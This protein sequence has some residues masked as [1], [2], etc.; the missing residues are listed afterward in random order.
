MLENLPG[1]QRNLFTATMRSRGPSYSIQY[2]ALCMVRLLRTTSTV[3]L[4]VI[5][6]CRSGP[7]GMLE[8]TE[9]YHRKCIGFCRFCI[10]HAGKYSGSAEEFISAT[11]QGIWWKR[12]NK[13]R[14]IRIEMSLQ[15]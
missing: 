13:I 1:Q 4:A 15:S 5:T 7:R 10:P 6:R 3:L 8:S 14:R 2:D 11:M 12:N 9:K